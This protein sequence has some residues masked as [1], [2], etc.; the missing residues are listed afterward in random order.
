[1]LAHHFFVVL[2]QHSCRTTFLHLLVDGLQKFPLMVAHSSMVN[3][4]DQLSVF[5]DEPRL[6]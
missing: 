6:P 1:M 2:N 5:V 3:F 4:L